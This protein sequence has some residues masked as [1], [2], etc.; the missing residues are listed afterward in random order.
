M[1]KQELEIENKNLESENVQ[2]KK[3]VESLKEKEIRFETTKTEMNYLKQAV[4]AK[5]K[6]LVKAK[7]EYHRELLALQK[8]KENVINE[9]FETEKKTLITEH[10]REINSIKAENETLKEQ[11]NQLEMI[12]KRRVGELNKFIFAHGAF[13]KS[14]QG[15]LETATAYNEALTIEVTK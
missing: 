1:T 14:V 6:E 3:Q 12:E 11:V 7:E 8:Q 2:L 4:E 10:E 15:A 9:N 13:L 5:D